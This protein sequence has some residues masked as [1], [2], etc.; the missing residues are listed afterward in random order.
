MHIAHDLRLRLLLTYCGVSLAAV[1]LLG[2]VFAAVLATS[3]SAAHVA[4]MR[5]E[6]SSLSRQLDRAFE[7]GA[8]R[9]AIQRLISGDSA[10]LG[11]QVILVDPSGQIRYDSTGLTTFAQG[12]WRMLDLTALHRGR[13]ARLHS[14]NRVGVQLPLVVHGREVGALALVINSA[15]AGIPW[16]QLMRPLAVM[17]SVLLAVWVAVA[18]VLSRSLSHPL[19]QVSEGLARVKDGEYDR[20]IREVGWSEAR[21]LARRYNE[22]VAEVARSRQLQRDFVANAAHELKT[23]VALL[24]GFARS[25]ADGTAQREDAVD[26]AVEY[27]QTESEHLARVVDQLF[28]LARLDADTAALRCAPCRP[29]HM[30][31]QTVTRFREQA[32]IRGKTIEM[33]CEPDMPACS[34]DEDQVNSAFTNL[35]SNALEHARGGKTILV[36]GYRSGPD[37]IF[38]VEDSGEGIDPDDLPHLFDR[39]YRGRNRRTGGHAGLGLAL[40]REVVERHGGAVRAESRA[41]A[42]SRFTLILPIQPYNEANHT[43]MSTSD[44]GITA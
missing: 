19:R 20:P 21:G 3:V 4:D 25:V 26:E 37:I 11:K 43:T 32:L 27:I 7:R 18:I 44:D 39:F 12:S 41:G 24:L 1:L 30:L 22:M 16:G 38:E 10:L 42:G 14:G 17:M 31:Q 2:S 29:A 15:N 35:L 36:R 6:A 13:S 34:W 23:P 33:A 5:G 8:K 40:V 9:G 28:A